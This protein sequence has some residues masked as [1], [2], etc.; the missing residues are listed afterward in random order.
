MHAERCIEDCIGARC[1][2]SVRKKDD[3]G[4]GG[5]VGER[6]R[7]GGR[8]KKGLLKGRKKGGKGGGTESADG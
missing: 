8:P 2:A 1:I 5:V 4:R 7:G 6:W 3:G